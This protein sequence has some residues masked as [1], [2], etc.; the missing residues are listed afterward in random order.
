MSYTNQYYP[1][2]KMQNQ[3]SQAITVHSTTPGQNRRGPWSPEEDRKL[4]ELISIFG[5]SNWVRISN[6]LNTRTP[7]QCRERYHQNLKPSLNRTPITNEE[8]EMIEKL[9]AKYGK[10]WAEI[11]RHLNGRSDNAIKNWWNGGANR[12]R[13]AS[14]QVGIKLDDEDQ[15]SIHS[16]TSTNATANT[17]DTGSTTTSSNNSLIEKKNNHALPPPPQS[18][19]SSASS[20]Q[21]STTTPSIYP[22]VQQLPQISFNTSMFGSAPEINKV[23]GTNT[24]PY[25]TQP[26]IRPNNLRLASFDIHSHNLPHLSNLLPSIIHQQQQQQ[27]QPQAQQQPLP[28]LHH[29]HHPHHSHLPHHVT[30]HGHHQ[31]AQGQYMYQQG[32]GGVPSTM[33]PT[34]RRLL[35][36]NSIT[37]RRHS[38]A[39]TM[40]SV[41]HSSA[42]YTN[43]NPNLTLSVSMN[44]TTSGSGSTGNVSPYY[45]SPLLLG[46]QPSR[47]NSIS[48][49]EFSTLTNS[50]NNSSAASRRSS[51]APDFFP[52]PLKEMSTNTSASAMTNNSITSGNCSGGTNSTNHNSPHLHKRN[53][54][55]NSF[56]SP[57]VTASGRF[58]ISAPSGVGK[59]PISSGSNINF[60]PLP[61]IPKDI[62]HIPTAGNTSPSRNNNNP[63]ATGPLPSI[64]PDSERQ[65]SLK[66]TI[67]DEDDRKRKTKIAVSSLID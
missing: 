66:Q 12:R 34:K 62:P 64:V 38:T 10:K 60:K 52:N 13:R 45:G 24:P 59:F 22:Q 15:Q 56:T 8:G 25:T 47:N 7:K 37:T 36:E 43:S 18:T 28:H 63:T 14:T 5:P 2:Q 4:M 31:L 19:S 6:T 42:F 67:D 61:P 49:F 32:P 3:P 57:S 1:P 58:S 54:S 16:S 29:S 41:P 9:V 40:Y 35:D 30:G 39:N 17:I 21:H 46:N 50:S 55:Q 27:Q 53:V 44:A 11:A 26:P 65:L 20:S 51:I 23:D 33:L 48:H